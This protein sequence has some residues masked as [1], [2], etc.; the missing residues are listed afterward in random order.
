MMKKSEAQS[1]TMVVVDNEKAY[2]N[3]QI[4]VLSS[5]E[6]FTNYVD[7]KWVGGGVSSPKGA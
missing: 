5:Q 4:Y 2:E 7:K 3:R 1:E 6:V